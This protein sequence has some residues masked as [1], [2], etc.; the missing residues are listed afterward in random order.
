MSETFELDRFVE[1]QDAAGTYARAQAELQ[2]GRKVSHWMWF[3]FPQVAGLGRS[4]IARRYA[5]SSL[6][7]ARAYLAHPVLGQRIRESARILTQYPGGDAEA[8]FGPVDALK[9]RSSMTLFAR[10]D[11]AQALFRAVLDQYFGGGADPATDERLGAQG[12]GQ[13]P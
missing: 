5:I 3:V 6:A 2:Q 1:A 8:I 4:P 12:T 13:G 9:L 7:E 11:P 10:A